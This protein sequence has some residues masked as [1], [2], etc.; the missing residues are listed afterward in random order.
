MLDVKRDA[1]WLPGV[2]VTG[3]D[4]RAAAKVVEEYDSDLVLGQNQETGDWIVFMRKGGPDGGPFPVLGF[5]RRLPAA[6]EVQRRLYE[7]DVRRH[8]KK[9]F[10][11]IQRRN[12]KVLADNK[13]AND[14]KLTE[15]A[16]AFVWAHRKLSSDSLPR[17]FIPKGVRSV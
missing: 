16:D 12:D 13:A 5:G 10:E 9:I 4:E 17:V 7:T 3:S 8:G 14:D 2:G 11:Q 6:D 15:A 1:M